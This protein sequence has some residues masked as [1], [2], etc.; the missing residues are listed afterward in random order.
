MAF[1]YHGPLTIV[2]REPLLPISLQYL[3]DYYGG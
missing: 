3:L 1:L 2:V